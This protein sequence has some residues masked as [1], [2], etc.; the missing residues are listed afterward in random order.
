MGML[1]ACISSIFFFFF[2]FS[3]LLSYFHYR[4]VFNIL[5]SVLSVIRIARS[6]PSPY[7]GKARMYLLGG[8]CKSFYNLFNNF[9]AIL[10]L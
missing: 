6:N 3:S 9:S 2:L 5:E 4:D 1:A 7:E 10:A 8:T